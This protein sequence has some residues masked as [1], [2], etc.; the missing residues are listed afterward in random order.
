MALSR[1]IG[2]PGLGGTVFEERGGRQWGVEVLAMNAIAAG[3][4]FVS[5]AT[6]QLLVEGKELRLCRKRK[7]A[8]PAQPPEGITDAE[9]E[10]EEDPEAAQ[11]Y[12]SLTR[13]IKFM[14]I[15]VLLAV[16]T[17]MWVSYMEHVFPGRPFFQTCFTAFT[18]NPLM[19]LTGLVYKGIFFSEP[20]EGEGIPDR[21]V[22]TVKNDYKFFP[23]TLLYVFPVFLISFYLI[24]V[25]YVPIYVA[26]VDFLSDIFGSWFLARRAEQNSAESKL[27]QETKRPEVGEE[28]HPE[29]EDHDHVSLSITSATIIN[30][31]RTPKHSY[32]PPPFPVAAPPAH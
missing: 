7:P 16:P 24:P 20:V 11:K 13:G 12:Y 28:F 21:I 15:N 6:A 22:R 17:T 31:A 30:A 27:L 4:A 2:F 3:I 10:E 8:G 14:G 32:H 18:W 26:L 1:L 5:D 29:A 19:F 23:F 9:A 25:R